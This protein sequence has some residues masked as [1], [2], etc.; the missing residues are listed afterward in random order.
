MSSA[1]GTFGGTRVLTDGLIVRFSDE[2]E[3]LREAALQFHSADVEKIARLDGTWDKCEREGVS[4][5]F[6]YT[7]LSGRDFEA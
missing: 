5:D 1:V 3:S 4:C 6:E 7:S 2:T